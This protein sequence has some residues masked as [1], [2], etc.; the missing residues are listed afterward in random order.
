MLSFDFIARAE[1]KF[2]LHTG[3]YISPKYLE[4]VLRTFP[5]AVNRALASHGFL[6]I[7]DKISVKEFLMLQCMILHK[8]TLQRN[9]MFFS[10]IL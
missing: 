1:K 10:C 6:P 9:S 2:S 4:Q 8:I 5:V 3:Y 7:E